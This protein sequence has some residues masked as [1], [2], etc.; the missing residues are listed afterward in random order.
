MEI[1]HQTREI[2]VDTQ[3]ILARLKAAKVGDVITYTEISELIGRDVR[4]GAR[5]LLRAARNW[6][7]R[8]YRI[9][10]GVVTGK[11]IQR[12]DDAGKVRAGA[13]EMSR[14]RRASRRAA[15]TLGTVEEFSELPNDMKIRHNMALS[16]FGIV[17]QA[18]STKVQNRIAEKVDGVEGGMLAMKKSLE[19]FA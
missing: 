2:S 3:V 18:T 19:L 6:A 17:Q 5:H 8:E 4:N 1:Q 10:F 15:Q 11:G 12:L 14:I 7:K 16:V 9:V 13:G